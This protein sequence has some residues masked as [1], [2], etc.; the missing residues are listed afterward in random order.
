MTVSQLF[1][2][3]VILDRN[4]LLW[5]KSHIAWLCQV[6]RHIN[7]LTVLTQEEIPDEGR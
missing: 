5:P 6:W 3:R 4:K 1:G 2:F 7:M